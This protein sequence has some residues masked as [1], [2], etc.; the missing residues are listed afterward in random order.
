VSKTRSISASGDL[1]AVTL[2]PLQFTLPWPPSVNHYYAV[3]RGRKIMSKAGRDYQKAAALSVLEQVGRPETILGPVELRIVAYVPD[4]RKR[5]LS[6]LVK[7]PED[8]LVH[9]RLIGDDCQV[10]ALHVL[11]GEMRPGGL[12]VVTLGALNPA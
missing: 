5:D 10:D 7:P 3:F 6:N 11:R 9:A 12:L 1:P 4:R 2:P 8:A